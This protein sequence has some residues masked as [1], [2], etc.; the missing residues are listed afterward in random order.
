M[1]D[2]LKPP[3]IATAVGTTAAALMDVAVCLGSIANLTPAT[4]STQMP[5]IAVF[6]FAAVMLIALALL[7]WVLYFRS[8]VD[9]R[10]DQSR[11][12]RQ[13]SNSQ[14]RPAG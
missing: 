3:V 11:Q 14:E 6:I 7:Q 1:N 4:Q 5:L 8:F 2:K 12:D 9:F 10:I 13:S